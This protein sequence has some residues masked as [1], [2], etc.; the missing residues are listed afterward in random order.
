[1]SLLG[2][3]QR[4]VSTYL[5]LALFPRNLAP[6]FSIHFSTLSPTLRIFVKKHDYS[7]PPELASLYLIL[8]AF[9]ASRAAKERY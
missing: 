7:L 1:M 5:D 9:R 2:F 3:N 6:I 8:F 4:T